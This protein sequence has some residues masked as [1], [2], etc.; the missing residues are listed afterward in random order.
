MFNATV[1]QRFGTLIAAAGGIPVMADAWSSPAELAERI[2]AVVVNGGTDVD[3]AR[4]GAAA[5]PTTNEPDVRRDTFEFGLVRAALQSELPVLGI[6]RG[7]Q[8]VNVEL[9]GSL[10]QDVATVTELPH[11]V[12]EPY[13]EPVHPIEIDADSVLARAMPERGAGV[14]SVHHQGVDR[15][16]AGLRPVAHAPDGTIEAIEDGS[17][18]V[19]GVQWHPE[20]LTGEA[21]AAQVG[22]FREFLRHCA[23]GAPSP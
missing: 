23:A 16:G 12:V 11:Y 15:L 2:D 13:D 17:G 5:A 19:L 6:C 7:M 18:R 3:P 21:G 1:N 8:L 4:Y 14:N 20:F 9:G 22:L 10:I